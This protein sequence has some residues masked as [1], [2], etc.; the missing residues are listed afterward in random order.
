MNKLSLALLALLVASCSA[1]TCLNPSGKPV[2]WWVQ[3]IFPGSVPGG[4]AYFDSTFTAPSFVIESQAPD[5]AASPMT[6]TL[7]QI[8]TM[9]L[10]TAAWNDENPN[11]TTSSSKAHS[12]GV[13]A[14]NDVSYVGFFVDHSM[15]K[16]P[17]FNGF[18]INTT[19][20]SS[21][22][23]Y[24][25]HAFCL[26]LDDSILSDLVSKLLPIRPYMYATNF[27]N[28]NVINNLLST[29]DIAAPDYT[30]L[31]TYKNITL[32]STQMRF[33]FKNGKVNGSIF[34]D[35]LNNMLG[36]PILA[37]TW[38]RPLQAPWC[39][40]PYVGNI[41]Y[42]QFNT[43]VN[44][45]ETQDH[46]KWAYAV[47]NNFVCFGDMNRMTSQWTRGGAFYCLNSAPL[48]QA[49]VS[50]TGQTQAC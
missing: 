7:S 19:I 39:G 36:S 23:I 43:Q 21:E 28:P 37:E 32:N 46:S 22:T 1:Q 41:N 8:N 47:N 2:T 27:N 30:D 14:Y 26:T 34:E 13:L 15:P 10:Q 33:I 12:K 24:G 5:S 49:M 16:F 4:Y 40:T 48:K 3:M 45:K 31:F 11:G 18:T 44:W 35:G 9:S 6:L 29:G 17:A 50:I 38:G 25:Q 20:D 42:I